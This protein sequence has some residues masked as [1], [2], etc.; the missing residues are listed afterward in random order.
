MHLELLKRPGEEIE[1]D[2]GGV[3]V[4]SER[5]ESESALRR[6]AH[7]TPARTHEVAVIKG[8]VRDCVSVWA[9]V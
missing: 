4:A 2:D 3:V 9:H 1:Y 7:Y 8:V 5:S 6:V